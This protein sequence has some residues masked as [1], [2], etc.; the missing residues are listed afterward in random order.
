MGT[1]DT[2]LSAC[3]ISCSVNNRAADLFCYSFSSDTIEDLNTIHR[4]CGYLFL[5][6]ILLVFSIWFK[7]AIFAK[8]DWEWLKKFG[9]YFGYRGQLPSARFNAGQKV[10]F[11]VVLFFAII[12][13][14]TGLTITYSEDSNLILIAHFFHDGV[15]FIFILA[16]MVHLYL[17]TLANPG[18]L[19]GIFEGKV[20]RPW[21][22]KHHPIWEANKIKN[23]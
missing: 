23:K 9:G 11:W 4:Y 17:S 5:L 6:N 21:A 22:K 13:G 8:Y 18:T 12:L 20:S 16:V 3:F 15:A 10:F 7:D 1:G 19:M 2:L 14:V